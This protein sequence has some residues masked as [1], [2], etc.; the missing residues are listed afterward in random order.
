MYELLTY[1]VCY[2]ILSLA[3]AGLGK[4]VSMV[5]QPGEIFGGWQKVLRKI[6]S[7]F[8]Y[9]SGG[10]CPT[11]IRQRIAE[12]TWIALLLLWKYQFGHS[13]FYLCPVWLDVIL[14]VGS[15]LLFCGLAIYF[16]SL[17]EYEKKKVEAI[18]KEYP[19]EEIVKQ[20]PL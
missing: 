15:Y 14:H 13:V 16:G 6:K 17:I 5:I 11:C 10:G 4:L 9:N 8:W 12:L 3:V 18:E 2:L 7:K 1:F 20:K 19:D